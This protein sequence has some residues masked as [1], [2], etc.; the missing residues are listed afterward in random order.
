MYDFNFEDHTH[1]YTYIHAQ[2]P[3]V[4]LLCIFQI[5]LG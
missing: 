3:K 1:T 2:Q 5:N 4:N